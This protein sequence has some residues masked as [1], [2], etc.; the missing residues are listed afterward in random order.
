VILLLKSKIINTKC[1]KKNIKGVKME[2]FFV[3][4][5]TCTYED[6][7]SVYDGDLELRKQFMKDDIVGKVDEN[8]AMIK[9]TITNPEKMEKIMSE[10]IP[11]I[12][13]KL[14]LEHEMYTLTKMN[15][16]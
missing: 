15:N 16:N 14:G 2:I 3:A 10:R 12:A 13:P 5:F 1:I 11:E 6:W 9:A 7:K 4:K 8:T